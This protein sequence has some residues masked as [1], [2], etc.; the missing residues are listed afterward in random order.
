ME[1]RFI[2]ETTRTIDDIMEY[3][4]GERISG[5]LAFLDFEKASDS[6]EW[7]FVH[8]CLE[9]F[10]FGS[11]FK[12]WVS[13]F[14]TDISSCVCNNGWQSEFFKIERGVRQGDP[15]SPYLFI[16][17]AEIL[18]IAIRSN[19]DIHGIKLG[20]NEIKL[21][22]YADDTTGILRD[23][24]SLGSLLQVLKSFEKVSGLKIDISKSECMWIGE[25]RN[26][27]REIFGLKWPNRPIKY[28]GVYITYDYDE[29]IKLNYKQR[30]KKMEKTANWWKGRGLTIYGR[31]QIINL[32]L[33]PKLVYL[34]SM[35]PVPEEVI[36]EANRIIFKFLWKDRD[37][38]A[39]N[40]VINS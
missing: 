40:A 2:G 19:T 27:K 16:I 26:C 23:E 25:S 15:L 8:T 13:M 3:T 21:L 11:D 36:K 1:G 24:A 30:L 31:A 6:V 37:R 14:Y 7:D 9:A 17:A 38:V 29:F 10:N 33:L 22:Q 32:L 28:L 18:A 4:K 39:R 20:N 12:K 5:I 35:F 34:S